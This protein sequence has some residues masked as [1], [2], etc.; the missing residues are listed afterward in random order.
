VW[1]QQQDVMEILEL[2]YNYLSRTIPSELGDFGDAEI[3]LK[4]NYFDV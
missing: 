2:Y 4:N 3:R 1:L